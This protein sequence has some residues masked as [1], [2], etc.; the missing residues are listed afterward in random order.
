MYKIKLL[1][2]LSVFVSLKSLAG[3]PVPDFEATQ[4]S[5]HIY[6]IFGPTDRPNPENLG[7]INNPAIIIGAD[8]A[9]IIDPGS[10]LESGRMVLRQLKKLTDKPVTDV[11]ISHIHGDHWLG[12]QAIREQYPNAKLYAHPEMI[13]KA[14]ESE[15]QFWVEI[16]N[17]LTKGAT[18]GTE[19]VIPEI[20]VSNGESYKIAGLTIRVHI[21]PAAH[22]FTDAM[23]EV[24]EDSVIMTGDNVTYKRM[25][26]FD[27]G[28][29]LGTI[30]MADKLLT[31]NIRSF[32]PGHGPSGDK[33]IV[34]SF[35]NYVVTLYDTVS[36]LYEEG[37][38][39]FEM[40]EK[41]VAKLVDYQQWTGFHE[42]IGRH[43]SLA[44]LEVE[45]AAFE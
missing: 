43:I 13:R 10:S 31:Q 26:R 29:F 41:I 1:V 18:D 33:K 19:A 39:D 15:A 45:K 30:K 16:L 8:S 2:L 37:M 11:F 4:I 20:P 21:M 25:P 27:E 14:K 17:T 3:T 28:T 7:F 34:E 22:S 24:V 23:Y 6:V 12:S 32:V 44:I 38:S 42:Q 35:R 36:L 9:I 5:E 40:K